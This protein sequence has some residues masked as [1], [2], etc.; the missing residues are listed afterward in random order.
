[1]RDKYLSELLASI[2]SEDSFLLLVKPVFQAVE[3]DYLYL[4]SAATSRVID[5]LGEMLQTYKWSRD[6][7]AVAICIRIVAGLWRAY[8]GDPANGE[9]SGWGH[10]S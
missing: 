3:K 7:G 1:M 6:E 10:D 9:A 2:H 5:R 4:G 8:G